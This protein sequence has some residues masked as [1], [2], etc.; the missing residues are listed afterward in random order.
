MSCH[1]DQW[2]FKWG[3][4]KGRTYGWQKTE[5]CFLSNHWD[6]QWTSFCFF[7]LHLSTTS[8]ENNASTV[9]PSIHSPNRQSA[10]CNHILFSCK[11]KALVSKRASLLNWRNNGALCTI[12][13]SLQLWCHSAVLGCQRSKPISHMDKESLWEKSAWH[14]IVIPWSTAQN[15]AI[16]IA[17]TDFDEPAHVHSVQ[18]DLSF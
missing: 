10:L 2:H 7:I 18:W 16:I 6:K 4:W 14:L 13:Y 12:G 1:T 17:Q 3:T 8:V 15:S 9:R 11:I 5:A